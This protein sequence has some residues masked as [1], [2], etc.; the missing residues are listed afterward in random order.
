MR[1]SVI[2]ARDAV[3]VYFA[4][5]AS[6]ERCSYGACRPGL[7]LPL[8]TRLSRSIFAADGRHHAATRAR[9]EK[10]RT[11]N[12]AGVQRQRKRMCNGNKTTVMTAM[13]TLMLARRM[14]QRRKHAARNQAALVW[15]V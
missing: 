9:F 1:E 6:R 12:Q 3:D 5:G 4:R 13:D 10:T 15:F 14:Q 7:L 8:S 11:Q 2:R